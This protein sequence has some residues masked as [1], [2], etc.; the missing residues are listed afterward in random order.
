MVY[1]AKISAHSYYSV[2]S[3]NLCTFL[4]H[5]IFNV[6]ISGLEGIYHFV[7]Q[8]RN[9]RTDSPYTLKS[10]KLHSEQYVSLFM[11]GN[12]AESKLICQK[13]F[14]LGLLSSRLSSLG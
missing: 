4:L 6:Q 11:F 12:V 1:L 14:R 5:Y 3:Y 10:E 13:S 8:E 9:L 7:L 2:P